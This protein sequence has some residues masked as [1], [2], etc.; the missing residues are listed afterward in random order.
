[1]TE[2]L[3]L[4]TGGTGY[5]GTVLA[6]LLASKYRVRTLDSQQFGNQLASIAT[7]E[8]V[9]GDITYPGDVEAA[10]QDVTDVIHLAGIVT[11][12]L[13]SMNPQKGYAVNVEG[14]VNVAYT[15]TETPTVQ[16]FIYV[17]SSSVYGWAAER[18]GDV[19]EWVEPRPKTAYAMQKL[20]GERIVANSFG[21]RRGPYCIVRPA[22]M[23]GPAPRPRLDTVV[24]VF[25]KQAFYDRRITVHGGSQY[26]SNVHVQDFAEVVAMLLDAPANLITGGIFNVTAGNMTVGEIAG[27]V[28]QAYEKQYGDRVLVEMQ[29][30]TDPRSYRLTAMQLLV[31]FGWQPKRTIED[32]ALDMFRLFESGRLGD[33]DSDLYHN[34]RRLREAMLRE[35]VPMGTGAR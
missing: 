7:I 22:T 11:D 14:T 4:V 21:V 23:C 24:N 20:Q 17:S 33:P 28:A 12:D 9:K 25:A 19:D 34:T 5:V 35:S 26:R 30:V 10:M 8:S 15:A 16:R 6:P 27:A 2:R 29:N 1:M 31:T 32:A 18:L 3:I 13:V